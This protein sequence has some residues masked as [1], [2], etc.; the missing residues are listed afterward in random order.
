MGRACTRVQR[1]AGLPCQLRRIPRR[2]GTF[3]PFDTEAQ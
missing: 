3:H 2:N 1:V